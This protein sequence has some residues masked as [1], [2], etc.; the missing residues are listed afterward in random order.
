MCI[1]GKEEEEENNIKR[2]LAMG[3]NL[4]IDPPTRKS[5]IPIPVQVSSD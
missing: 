5:A 3:V 2:F 4:Y 1:L